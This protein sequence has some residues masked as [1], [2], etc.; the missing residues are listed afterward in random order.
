MYRVHSGIG[1]ETMILM[2]WHHLSAF[3]SVIS[4]FQNMALIILNVNLKK[5]SQDLGKVYCYFCAKF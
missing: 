4:L 1:S 2:S 3:F 5:G